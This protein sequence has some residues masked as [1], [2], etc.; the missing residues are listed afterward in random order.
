VEERE[1]DKRGAEGIENGN[2]KEKGEREG[3]RGG[4]IEKEEQGGE[5]NREGK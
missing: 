4:E 2:G 3:K 1:K 5:A